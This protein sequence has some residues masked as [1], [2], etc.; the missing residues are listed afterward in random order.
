MITKVTVCMTRTDYERIV[1]SG[2]VRLIL[3]VASSRETICLGFQV[4]RTA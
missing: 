4:S 3:F 1:Q 2:A